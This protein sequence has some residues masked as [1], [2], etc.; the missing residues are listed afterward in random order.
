S[1]S[2]TL[3]LGGTVPSVV[4]STATAS[5]AK[6]AAA[7][8]GSARRTHAAHEAPSCSARRRRD[9]SSPPRPSAA[10]ATT[11]YISP[12]R[13]QPNA[14]APSTAASRGI[15]PASASR[16]KSPRY[17][18]STAPTA[19][20]RDTTTPAPV[21]RRG[22]HHHV[23]RA[24]EVPAERARPLHRRLRGDLP[25][26]RV[27]QDVTAILALHRR[28]RQFA[29]DHQRRHRRAALRDHHVLAVPRA[30]G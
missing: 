17:L 3:V 18:P 22:R 10:A 4:C 26:Q 8:C 24:G 2:A 12:V 9:A 28:Y 19:S 16:R 14:R 6:A 27:A 7:P 30:V 25:G 23:H 11:T 20:A 29:G 21:V 13:S 15:C 5:A 1:S